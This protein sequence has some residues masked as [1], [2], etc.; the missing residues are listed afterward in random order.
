AELQIVIAKLPGESERQRGVVVQLHGIADVAADAGH[1]KIS[2]LDASTQLRAQSKAP[3]LPA[4]HG[5]RL[6]QCKIEADQLDRI[7]YR[8]AP[9][10]RCALSGERGIGLFERADGV[11]SRAGADQARA[12][13]LPCVPRELDSLASGPLKGRHSKGPVTRCKSTECLG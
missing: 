10:L 8:P 13:R 2:P 7:S 12:E 11:T 1:G 5:G 4:L 6:S 9:G 3:L